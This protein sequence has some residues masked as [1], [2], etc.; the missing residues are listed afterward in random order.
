MIKNKTLE[1][2]AKKILPRDLLIKSLELYYNETFREDQKQGYYSTFF[3]VIWSLKSKD[4][5]YIISKYPEEPRLK[6]LYYIMFYRERKHS[7]SSP[8][9]MRAYN[10]IKDI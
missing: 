2:K 5:S 8:A 7:K 9:K 1:H 4:I 3:D 6:Q 10:S